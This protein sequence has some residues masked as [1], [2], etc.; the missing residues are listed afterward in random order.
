[1]NNTSFSVQPHI[2]LQPCCIVATLFM[3]CGN[4]CSKIPVIQCLIICKFCFLP[5]KSI[6]HET[7]AGSKK[8]PRVFVWH[9]LYLVTP[10]LL[11]HQLL[12]L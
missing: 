1:M 11:L 9:L 10:C 4:I 8:P 12:K 3:N 7:G 6:R 2:Q 5:E